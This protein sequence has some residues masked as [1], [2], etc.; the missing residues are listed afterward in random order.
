MKGSFPPR[1]AAAGAL[2]AI[3]TA[4]LVSTG[5]GSASASGSAADATVN[6]ATRDIPTSLDPAVADDNGA[7]PY[8]NAVYETLVD[9]NAQTRTY[10]PELATAWD[11]SNGAKTWT[12]TIRQGV[13]FHDGS[14]LTA[15]VAAESLERTIAVG[16]G[17]SF[18]LSDVS[19]IGAPS[20]Y[21][22]AIELKAP[23]AS[24]VAS[25][26][27]MFI[28]SG[29]AIAAHK[30]DEG[31]TWF[32]S[33]DAGSGP[34]ELQKWVPSNQVILTKFP[35]YWQGWSGHHVT[36][37]QFTETEPAAEALE[38]Q[39]GTAD[40]TDAVALQD[41][42]SMQSQPQMYKVYVDP[43]VP[44]YL[45]MNMG[46][47]ALKNLAVREA[48]SD[49]V[50]YQQIIQDIMLGFATP[51]SGPAPSWVSGYD[52]SLQAPTYNLSEAKKLAASAGYSPSHP[53]NLSLVY[54]N[55]LSFEASIATE[56]QANLKQIGVNLTVS[57]E[58]WPTLVAKVGSASTRPDLGEVAAGV[59]TSDAGSVLDES[60]DPAE[61][62]TY[63]YWGYDDPTTIS[64]LKAA[65]SATSAAQA[66]ADEEQV[67]AAVVKDYAMIWLLNNPNVVVAR[68]DI[69]NLQLNPTE[70]VFNYYG[71]WKS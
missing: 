54:Y 6:V 48:I 65:L 31:Q 59:P 3:L 43:G 20:T 13:K 51:L 1:R 37:Y 38:L 26:S 50:P 25:L 29:K 36:T 12:L 68:S 5:G 2:A 46:T 41:I 24:F 32:A 27:Q 23:D 28:M 19:H 56:V 69:H 35:Q 52:K 55:G 44:L 9:Y 4:T 60:F 17:E 58:P 63:T 66:A 42:K 71:V 67:Q 15:A 39:R 16:K 10:V 57:G 47:L 18:L 14:T 40:V 22:L 30:A 64:R 11:V 62:G 45:Y 7:Y 70:N 61:N 21:S 53:L 49:A 33:H 34:Y 8:M